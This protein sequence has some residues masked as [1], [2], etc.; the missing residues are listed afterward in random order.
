[1]LGLGGTSAVG[2]PAAGV[3][4]DAAAFAAKHGLAFFEGPIAKRTETLLGVQDT[5]P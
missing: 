3:V 5:Y 1:V 2:D 4:Q